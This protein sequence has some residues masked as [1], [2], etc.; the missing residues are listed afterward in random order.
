MDGIYKIWVPRVQTGKETT[1]CPCT[2]LLR[3]QRAHA[4]VTMWYVHCGQLPRN[5]GAPL[6]GR[7]D[8]DEFLWKEKLD[9]LFDHGQFLDMGWL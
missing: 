1:T 3:T 5:T 9:I 4:R 2:I 6:A 7:F 8:L